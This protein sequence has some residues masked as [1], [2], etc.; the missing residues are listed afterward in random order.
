MHLTKFG[1]MDE[2]GIRGNLLTWFKSYLEERNQRVVIKNTSSSMVKINAGVPRISVLGPFL[3]II[4]IND[5]AEK[6]M[7]L[8]R[9]FAD[10]ISFSYSSHDEL[11]NSL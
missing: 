5:I 4:Y 10:D 1:K 11:Q 3:F 7:S 6:L 2:Y 9:L 8:C